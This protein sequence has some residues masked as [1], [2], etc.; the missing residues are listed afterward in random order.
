MVDEYRSFLTAT[1]H[2]SLRTLDPPL[3]EQAAALRA[4]YQLRTPD[5]VQIAAAIE[6]GAPLFLTND[7]RLRKVTE[8][9]VVV[10][11]RWLREHPTSDADE[12]L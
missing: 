11:E 1:P 8:I 12:E 4:R 9:E 6:F 7:D 10:L 2:L 3:A 5:A